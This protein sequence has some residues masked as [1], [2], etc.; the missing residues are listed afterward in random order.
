MVGSERKYWNITK[1]VKKLCLTSKLGQ[2]ER[3]SHLGGDMAPRSLVALFGSGFG[4]LDAL[5]WCWGGTGRGGKTDVGTQ[6][7]AAVGVLGTS[8]SC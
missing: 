2:F 1:R 3:F 8:G 7:E 5:C 6:L 4:L